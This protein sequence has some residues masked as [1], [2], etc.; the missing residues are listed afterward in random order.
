MALQEAGRFSAQSFDR[1]TQPD[2]L[3]GEPTGMQVPPAV[4]EDP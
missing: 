4:V 1:L 2:V 3:L